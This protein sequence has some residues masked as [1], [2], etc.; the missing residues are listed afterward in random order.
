MAVIKAGNTPVTPQSKTKIRSSSR[1]YR[2]REGTER[3]AFSRDRD[4]VD[5]NAIRETLDSAQGQHY[6][7]I[8]LNAGDGH[9]AEIDLKGWTRDTMGA[10]AE[11]H[12]D[13]TWLAYEHREHSAHDHVH[14]IA[15]TEARLSKD[16]LARM[17]EAA[18]E[19][20]RYH[21]TLAREATLDRQLGAHERAVDHAEERG[22][23]WSR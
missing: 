14:V 18:D 20:W 16:D 10:L 11:R 12:G 7:R 4:V 9:N 21:K 3:E 13:V 5:R 17:R 23:S 2:T 15:V 6:Y 1:Y 22:V 8:V 19:S